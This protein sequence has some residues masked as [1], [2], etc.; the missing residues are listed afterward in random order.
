MTPAPEFTRREFLATTGAAA[1]LPS[2][3]RPSLATALPAPPS[4]ATFGK[5]K[6]VVVLY[7]YGAPSQM[8]TLDP[9][10]DAPVERRGEF[11]TIPTRLPGIRACEHLPRI[12]SVLDRTCLV[13]SMT[14]SSNNHAV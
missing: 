6:S 12:A 14:H 13:R 9:K 8:D 4:S 7:L 3:G 11:G 1:V 2:A 5:A 10:P